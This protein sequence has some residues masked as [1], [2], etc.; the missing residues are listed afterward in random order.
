MVQNQNIQLH[1]H[2]GRVVCPYVCMSVLVCMYVCMYVCVFITYVLCTSVCI[3][4]HTICTYVCMYYRIR[5][6]FR[7]FR[8]FIFAVCDVIAQALP[9]WSKFSRDETFA[10][11]Y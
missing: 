4:I 8:V 10:D 9:V 11:G 3:Y 2:C 7:G 1:S 6:N 5:F